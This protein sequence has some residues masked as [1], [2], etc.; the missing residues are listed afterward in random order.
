MTWYTQRHTK[1]STSSDASHP[2]A[3]HHASIV[4]GPWQRYYHACRAFDDGRSVQLCIALELVLLTLQAAVINRANLVCCACKHLDAR[5]PSKDEQYYASDV[6][7]F[8][9]T[10]QS[11]VFKCEGAKEVQQCAWVGVQVWW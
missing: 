6:A 5:Q 3:F 8:K 4:Y 7:L 1:C 2:Q 11:Q 9:S 10:V